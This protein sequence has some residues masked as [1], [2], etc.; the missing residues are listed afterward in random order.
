MSSKGIQC[1]RSGLSVAMSN[2]DSRIISGSQNCTIRI[3]NIHNDVHK[4]VEY[5]NSVMSV[6]ISSDGTS[7][8]SE[9]GDEMVRIWDA[10][11]GAILRDFRCRDYI[12]SKIA[13]SCNNSRVISS[14][15]D[16]VIRIWDTQ[17]QTGSAVQ[18]LRAHSVHSIAIL[19]DDSHGF[20]FR[21]PRPR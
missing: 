17:S 18:E 20:F 15:L 8:V 21:L 5:S 6:A 7:I 12:P 19:R 4:H 13:I 14:S 3:W 2:D 9:P 10:K 11:T 16:T 1:S